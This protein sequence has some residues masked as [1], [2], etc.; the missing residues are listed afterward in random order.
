M[1]LFDSSAIASAYKLTTEIG[2]DNE[3]VIAVQPTNPYGTNQ[4]KNEL[5]MVPPPGDFHVFRITIP[6]LKNGYYKDFPEFDGEQAITAIMEL[7]AEVS[8][9]Q[10]VGNQEW[11]QQWDTTHD[12]LLLGEIED[13]TEEI[14][15]NY[16]QNVTEKTNYGEKDH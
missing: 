7:I 11:L 13:Y 5:A 6:I 3:E 10:L 12:R 15:A 1:G 16:S 2:S 9:T 4:E 14:I 8:E